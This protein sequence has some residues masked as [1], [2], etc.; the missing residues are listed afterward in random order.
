MI[1]SNEIAGRFPDVEPFGYII[2]ILSRIGVAL[3]S[4]NGVHGLTWQ[5]IDAF[6]ARTQL[7]L[8]GWEAETIKRLSALYASSVLKYDNQDAQVA[9]PHRRRT[10]RHRQRHEISSTRTRY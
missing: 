8:T 2:E 10:E 9:L 4:G 3:N 5:E 1:D 7:H 6:V